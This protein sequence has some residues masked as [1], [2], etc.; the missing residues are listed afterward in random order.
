MTH[1]YFSFFWLILFCDQQRLKHQAKL[2]QYAVYIAS[3]FTPNIPGPKGSPKKPTWEQHKTSLLF[4]FSLNAL[5]SHHFIL[6]TPRSITAQP[7]KDFC[8]SDSF[9][10]SELPSPL[11]IRLSTLL[12]VNELM[13]TLYFRLVE[14][15]RATA[16]LQSLRGRF[17]IF[18][19]WPRHLKGI[20][21]KL[22]S[23]AKIRNLK[24]DYC[25][26]KP[27]FFFKSF[28]SPLKMVI[29]SRFY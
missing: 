10:S 14:T 18:K 3:L 22:V 13:Q 20:K 7:N 6:C 11:L 25:T 15:K 16:Q 29:L 5:G 9:S 26:H 17:S 23:L 8:H 27:C 19:A 12:C 2:G 28:R 24:Q 21:I 1:L 4:W